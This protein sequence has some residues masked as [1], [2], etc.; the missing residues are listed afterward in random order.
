MSTNTTPGLATTEAFEVFEAAGWERQASGYHDFFRAITTQTV[1][2]LLDGAGVGQ[3]TRLLDVGTGPGYVAGRAAD[4][5]ADAMGIDIADAMVELARRSW[6]T[7]GFR[8]ADAHDLPFPDDAFSAVTANFVLLHLGRPERAAREIARV[9]APGGGV[10][11]T[12]W[13]EPGQ[14]PM[15]GAVLTAL[16]A[17]G[18]HAPDDI[19]A[20]PPF[21]RFSDEGELRAL[22]DQADFIEPHVETLRFMQTVASAEAIW[23]GLM[24]GTV[25]TSAL[26]VRQPASVQEQIHDAFVEILERYREGPTLALPISVKLATATLQPL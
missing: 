15:L 10:A 3:G 14:L 5:G 19:P 17:T 4:R 8:R 21:F 25:R 11:L 13:D 18:A 1:D 16:G 2:A 24:A 26:V 9:L 6:P 7:A 23:T 22:L 20:G 12:V